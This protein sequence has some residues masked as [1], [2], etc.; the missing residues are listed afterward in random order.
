MKVFEM[1]VL[2]VKWMVKNLVPLTVL[3]KAC[4]YDE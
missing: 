4:C 2:K 1:E 3:L